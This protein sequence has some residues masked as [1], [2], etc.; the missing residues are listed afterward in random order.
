MKR[1]CFLLIFLFV[2][3]WV[4]TGCLPVIQGISLAPPGAAPA[5]QGDAK[6]VTGPVNSGKIQIA[7]ISNH[8]KL[9]I[10]ITPDSSVEPV[11]DLPGDV[12]ASPGTGDI[13]SIKD[14]EGLRLK[15]YAD[16][17][18]KTHIG[19]GRNLTDKGISR[20]EADVLYIEDYTEAVE[21]LS[22]RV[23]SGLWDGLPEQAKA[24]LINMRYQLGPEGF[25]GFSEMIKA[26]TAHDWGRMADEMRNSEWYRDERTR[27]RAERLALI[28]ERIN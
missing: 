6:P 10:Y 14:D 16:H 21:D 19:Y 15:P 26:V 25:R 1:F 20:D 22:Q 4:L 11:P 5:Q 13:T 24:V 9:N 7:E 2:C 23:F 18:G 8:G 17:K 27:P 3:G 28:V 12:T